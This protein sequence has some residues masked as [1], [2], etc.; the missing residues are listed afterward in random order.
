MKESIIEQIFLI[1][2]ASITQVLRSSRLIQNSWSASDFI[3]QVVLVAIFSS[4]IQ[5]LYDTA[6]GIFI[7]LNY[8]NKEV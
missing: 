7:L 1:I 6:N 3:S 5:I 8:E 2:G 4:A